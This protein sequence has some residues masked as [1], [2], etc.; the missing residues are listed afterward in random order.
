MQVDESLNFMR[1]LKIDG[2]DYFV[3]ACGITS[4]T[5]I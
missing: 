1:V 4:L 5:L 2:L 3:K